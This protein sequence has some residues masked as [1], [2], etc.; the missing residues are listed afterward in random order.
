MRD[1]WWIY[2]GRG[3]A[4]DDLNHHE[5]VRSVSFVPHHVNPERSRVHP[6]AARPAE[7]LL[8]KWND[9]TLGGTQLSGVKARDPAKSRAAEWS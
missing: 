4:P 3:A 2:L 1:S 7:V 9:I 6:L 5:T 8:D